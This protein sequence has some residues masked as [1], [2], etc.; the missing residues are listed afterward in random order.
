MKDRTKLQE[1]VLELLA[2]A[3]MAFTASRSPEEMRRS[4]SSLREILEVWRMYNE[5]VGTAV[6]GLLT[7]VQRNCKHPNAQR[8]HNER[9]GSWMNTCPTCGAS[10]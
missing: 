10:E 9:D 3:Q 1:G 5:Q 4:T 8:G 2:E 7:L 6:Y